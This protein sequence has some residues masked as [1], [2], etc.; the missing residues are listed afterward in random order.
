MAKLFKFEKNVREQLDFFKIEIPN[1]FIF[2]DAID[3][4]SCYIPLKSVSLEVDYKFYTYGD[5][6]YFY[7]TLLVGNR[8]YCGLFYKDDYKFISALVNQFIKILS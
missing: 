7:L 8:M 5:N 1:G 2:D 3:G 6:E 4:F